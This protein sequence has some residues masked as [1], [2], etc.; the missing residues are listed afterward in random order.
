MTSTILLPIIALG[1]AISVG[2]M[3]TIV[4]DAMRVDFTTDMDVDHEPTNETRKGTAA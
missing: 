2:R 1:L 3:G 4:K